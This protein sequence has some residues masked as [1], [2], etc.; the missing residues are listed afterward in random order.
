MFIPEDLEQVARTFRGAQLV[1]VPVAAPF[2]AIIWLLHRLQ[3]VGRPSGRLRWSRGSGLRRCAPADRQAIVAQTPRSREGDPLLQPRIVAEEYLS[4]A[5]P[6]H[7]A[8]V[9]VWLTILARNRE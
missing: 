8:H 6:T 2:P 1:P 5:M 7:P 3:A 4:T 9:P